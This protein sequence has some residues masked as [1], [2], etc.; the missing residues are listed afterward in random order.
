[1]ESSVIADIISIKPKRIVYVSCD[2]YTMARDLKLLT[3]G[4]YELKELKCVNMFI[5][6]RHIE[7]VALLIRR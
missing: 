4:G 1:M 7:S 5:K 2:S 3:M 6:S